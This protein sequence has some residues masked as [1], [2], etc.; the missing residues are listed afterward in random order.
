MGF[1]VFFVVLG[2]FVVPENYE[3]AEPLE[4]Q[5]LAKIAGIGTAGT[6]KTSGIGTAGTAKTSGIGTAGTAGTAKTKK[7]AKTSGI[8]T[9]GIAGIG[10]AKKLESPMLILFMAKTIINKCLIN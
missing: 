8:R 5:V 4:L 10:T 9:T 7:N 3:I 1:Y 6:A 2:V